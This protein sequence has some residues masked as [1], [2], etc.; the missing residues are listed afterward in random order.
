MSPVS[1]PVP[2]AFRGDAQLDGCGGGRGD[3]GRHRCRR[4]RAARRDWRGR[5]GGAIRGLLEERS[6]AGAAPARGQRLYE[7]ETVGSWALA[8]GRFRKAVV[9]D[10]DL[11]VA[12]TRAFQADR[13][14]ADDPHAWSTRVC[15]PGSSGCGRMGGR[16]AAPRSVPTAGVGGFRW[17]ARPGIAPARL[18]QACVGEVRRGTV[19]RA[20]GPCCTPTPP[21]LS[22]RVLSRPGLSCGCGGAALRLRRTPSTD[23]V[24]L[25]GSA[26]RPRRHPSC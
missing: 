19:L 26:R 20:T 17:C 2:A 10:R 11:L 14:G 12:S 21:T 22:P 25:A 3:G 15:P 1:C 8:P 24:R 23:S 4:R 16:F 5:D 13:R 18:R 7:V 9:A 6:R